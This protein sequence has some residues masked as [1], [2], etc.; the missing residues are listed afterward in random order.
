MRRFWWAGIL[1][2]TL[3]GPSV[4]LFAQESRWLPPSVSAPAATL[5]VPAQSSATVARGTSDDS[6]PEVT[7]TVGGGGGSRKPVTST[8]HYFEDG[9]SRSRTSHWGEGVSDWCHDHLGNCF[10]GC[11]GR[12]A[13]ESDHAFDTFAS[14]V[15]NPFLFEDPRSLT[16]I[17]PLFFFQTIPNSQP[18]FKGGNAE[19]YGVQGRLA[20][21]DRLS[22]VFNELGGVSINPGDSSALKSQTG[23]AQMSLGPKYTF[24]RSPET[25]TI[26]AAGLN[27]QIPSGPAK[28][29][30]DTGTL[31]LVP[32]VSGA[33]NFLRS[34]YGSFNVMETFGYS[35]SIDSKRSE[36]LYN[37]L[38]LDYD[39]ANLH[40]I[41]PLVELNWFDYTRAGTERNL[42]VEGRDLANIGS[43]GVS[44]R[45][46]LSI[47]TGLRYKFSERAQVGLAA[48]FPL[49]G[50]RDLQDFRLTIDFIFRY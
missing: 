14:P 2:L 30:Q 6:T 20:V 5:G 16:E 44:G 45:N 8:S 18:L 41:Y 34:S 43:R 48:E 21:T 42:N 28:V 32:Y 3:A 26:A 7:S 40:R 12:A 27:F 29:Y 31:S 19:F 38:H 17:K 22:F 25:Q 46:E 23:F 10:T 24:L 35:F 1:G 39:V 37:S 9:T 47:A 33:Q 15:T 50:N 4:P 11:N 13:F 49:N 36:F